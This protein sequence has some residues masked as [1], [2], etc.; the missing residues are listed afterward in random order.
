PVVPSTPLCRSPPLELGGG[1]ARAAM[2]GLLDAS[3]RRLLPGDTLF[4]YVRVT[5]NSPARQTGVSR[6]YKVRL[7][8]MGELRDV[9]R[10]GADELV[11]DASELARAARRLSEQTRDLGRRASTSRQTDR[12]GRGSD[13]KST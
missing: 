5:D 7:P 12:E 2:L 13:R 11:A 10:E 4:Y 9:A 1:Q 3:E 8:S 6:T